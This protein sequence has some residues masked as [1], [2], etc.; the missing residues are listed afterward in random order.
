VIPAGAEFSTTPSKRKKGV[1][2]WGMKNL[3]EYNNNNKYKKFQV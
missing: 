3:K 2:A 1:G